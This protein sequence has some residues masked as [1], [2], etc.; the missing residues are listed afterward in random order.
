MA[1]REVATTTRGS[2]I[3]FLVSQTLLY[4]FVYHVQLYLFWRRAIRSRLTHWAQ[5]AS[6]SFIFKAINADPVKHHELNCFG[7]DDVR[8]CTHTS[9][10]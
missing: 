9:V 10:R 8:I 7:P 5:I 2:Y 6:R 3:S 1:V 4:V